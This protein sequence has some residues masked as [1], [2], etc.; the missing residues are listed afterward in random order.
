MQRRRTPLHLAKGL[1]AGDQIQSGVDAAR[2]QSG[3]TAPC[4]CAI[5]RLVLPFI[6]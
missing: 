1:K 4:R 6:T 5:S 3:K 2:N